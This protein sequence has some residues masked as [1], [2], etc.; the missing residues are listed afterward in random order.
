MAAWGA[1]EGIIRTAV[2]FQKEEDPRSAL[3]IEEEGKRKGLLTG[4]FLAIRWEKS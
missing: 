1:P 2:H 3:E 4:A